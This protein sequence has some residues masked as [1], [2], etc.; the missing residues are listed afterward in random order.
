[1]EVFRALAV[2]AEPPERAGAG[3]VAAALGLGELPE[4]SAYT[5]TF[6]FQLYP[7]ASVYLGA[8]GMMGGEARDRV[9]GFWRALGQT[10]PPEP[11]YLPVMLALYA[12]LCDFE[13]SEPREPERAGWRGARRAFLWEHLLSWL[14][15]YLDKLAEVAPP[16]YRGWG[17]LLGAALAEEAQEVGPQSDLPL[18]LREAAPVPAP[19]DTSAEEFLSS[20]LAPARTGMILTRSDLAR[21]AR[22]LGLGLR[23]GERRFALEA[24]FGQDAPAVLGWLSGEAREW[25][26]RH[27][28]HRDAYGAVAAW[29][30][31][32]AAATAV[33]M[34]SLADE[35]HG[36][37]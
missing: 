21:A 34:A 11:D 32:R 26:A 33:L 3:H 6:I 14:P 7:Y 8:E 22:S 35:A 36:E 25:A 30:S 29:W 24:M 23:A 5:D 18:A 9:A 12:R 1:M 28:R 10:P 4:Q 37:G 2:L 31:E 15:A 16:F 27:A 19:R 17:K 20:L 13:V